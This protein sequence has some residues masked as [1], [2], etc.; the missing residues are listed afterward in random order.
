MPPHHP[1]AA[2][3]S[4]LPADSTRGEGL[5]ARLILPTLILIALAIPMAAMSGLM[6]PK[7]PSFAPP[8]VVGDEIE[9]DKALRLDNPL[10]VDARAAVFYEQEHIPGAIRLTDHDWDTQLGWFLAEWRPGR[11]VVV[12]CNNA[13]CNASK[14]VAD[15]IRSE[16]EIEPVYVLRNGWDAWLGSK[17]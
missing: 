14:V 8:V 9:L 10:W 12:Y 16:L 11:P 3:Q 4:A 2:P 13:A 17:R 5:F 1:T 6:H 15:R 7:A